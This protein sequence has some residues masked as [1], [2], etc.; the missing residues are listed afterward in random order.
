MIIIIALLV[1]G[2][3]L[4][5]TGKK[6]PVTSFISK[7]MSLTVLLILFVF[8]IKIG[9]DRNLIS[10]IGQLGLSAFVLSTIT[11]IGSCTCAMLISRYFAKR[12]KERGEA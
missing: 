4:G 2:I 8:G 7:K 1:V 11:I 12:K 9:S 6:Y 5:R 10:K 3:V